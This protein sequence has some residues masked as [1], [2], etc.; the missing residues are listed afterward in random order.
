MRRKGRSTPRKRSGAHIARSKR[1]PGTPPLYRSVAESLRR[2][3]ARGRIAVGSNL[4]AESDLVRRF[5]VSR[6]TIR[7]ALRQLRDDGLVASRQGAGTVVVKTTSQAGY[8]QTVASI[9]E[10]IPYAAENRYDISGSERVTCG[11]QLARK[12]GCA[13]GEEWLRITGYRYPPGE[14]RPICWTEVYI[15]PQF[16]RAIGML[17]RRNGA[18]YAWIEK[19]YGAR[20][21]EVRQTLRVREMPAHLARKLRSEAGAPAVEV[22]RVYR[23]TT[24]TVA[25][26]AFNLH[27]ADRFSHSMTLRRRAP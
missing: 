21:A 13:R 5:A 27:P 2:D 20:F 14:T 24:G 12:L 26:I 16:S 8:V 18:I 17:S 6:H 7:Q 23:L 4:P 25:E 9:E 10:L 3:I 22:C 19:L 15:R 11:T 1:I